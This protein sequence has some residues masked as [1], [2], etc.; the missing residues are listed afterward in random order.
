[1]RI[2]LRLP[3]S[4][5]VNRHTATVPT[6]EILTM[7]VE[8]LWNNKLRTA[9]TMLGVIIGITS[10]IA[11][12]S[13]GQGVQKATEQQIQALGTDVLQIFPAS[14][15]TGG[16]SQGVGSSS[17]LTWQDAKA[18]QQQ[19]PAAEVVSAY[20]QRPGQVVYGNLNHSTNIVGIDLN[21]L[22]ARNTNLTQGR[23]F[24]AQEMDVAKSIAILGPT[25]RNELFGSNG[26]VIGEQI[27]IQRNIYEVIGVFEKKGSEGSM[28]RDDQVFIPLTNMSSLVVGNNALNGFAVNG[29]YIKVA[30]GDQSKTAEFQV[31][32][33][34]R[35]RHNLSP[36]QSDDFTIRNRTDIVNTF[37][38]VVGLF[39]VMIVAIAS[40]SL[41]VGGIGIANI[42]LVSV[43]E[44]TR[45]IGI[46]KAVGATNSAILHQFLAE[47]V[48]ISSVGGGIGVGIGIL[49]AFASAMMFNFP[50]VVSVWSVVC[51]FG[52][53][54]IVGLLA[55]VIPARNAA[56]LDPIVSLRSD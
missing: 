53:S 11:I 26:N 48:V 55:G 52:L 6:M 19:A 14:A 39:T 27:R 22:Q 45:E 2:S 37:S 31:V 47:S 5:P 20:L 15:R 35:L 36:L 18:I 51:G 34:L 8:A 56:Q 1:M 29:I 10:V 40:I 46:R 54:F 32:N 43:V 24:T 50:F 41:L 16:I 33:L 28:D 38:T 17:T 12:T 13:V 7:A 4:M 21:Y 44:R 3:Q 25:V 9:L 42:M 49:I 23:F 30:D